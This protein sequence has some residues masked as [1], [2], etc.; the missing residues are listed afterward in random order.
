M[1]YIDNITPA[2]NLQQSTNKF[3]NYLFKVSVPYL[4]TLSEYEMKTYGVYQSGIKEIDKG[5]SGQMT[6]VFIATKDILDY[7]KQGV[8]IRLCSSNDIKEIYITIQEYLEAWKLML[9]N[10]INLAQAPSTDLLELDSL[11]N[12]VFSRAKYYFGSGEAET[13]LSGYLTQVNRINSHNFFNQSINKIIN[14]ETAHVKQNANGVTT[15]NPLEDSNDIERESL[16]DYFKRRI[17]STK[18]QR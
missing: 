13:V 16:S 5:L 2:T 11:A 4:A 7:F 14:K 9:Q 1:Y 12:E 8:T 17:H 10:G 3:N 15:I 6:N 18:F